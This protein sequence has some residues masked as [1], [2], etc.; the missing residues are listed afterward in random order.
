MDKATREAIAVELKAARDIGDLA[1]KEA[2]DF[3]TEERASVMAHIEAAKALKARAEDAE[4]FRKQL[5]DL[6]DGIGFDPPADPTAPKVMPNDFTAGRKNGKSTLGNSFVES[7]E[8]KDMLA[9]VPGGRF[10]EKSRVQ[11][12]P[13]GVKDLL[14]G[15]D[16]DASAGALLVPQHLGLLDPYY[17]RPL[18]L[19]AMVTNGTTATDTIDFVRLVSV[20][21]NAAP[22][23]EASTAAAIGSGS[24]GHEV[25]DAQG[26][27]KPQGAM[28]FEKDSTTVKTIAQWIPATKRALSDASQVRTL[29]DAFLLYSLE[30]E[31]EDQIAG[32]DGTGENL[33]GLSHTSGVQTQDAATG[34]QDVFDITRIARRKVRIGGRSIPT[35]YAMNPVDWEAIEL[36]RNTQGIFYGAGPFQMSV[37]RLWGLPVIESEAIPAGTGYVADWSKAVL[38]DRE[39]AS[40]QVTDSHEDF[41]VRNLVAILA[42]LRVGFAILRPPAFV[43]IDL[44]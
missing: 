40:I 6:S 10:G 17:Q 19:R 12:A 44:S 31:L 24:S 43:K 26:G 11:S 39:Q 9:S 7:K 34:G 22:V 1:E 25:T 18:T 36:M 21:N 42:E 3:T 4:S 14:T 37:P 30:E 27:V 8:F 32:G 2:R 33:L 13:Y 29:I 23:P 35:A 16:R 38:W 41:F 15:T 28:V 20:T 5:T